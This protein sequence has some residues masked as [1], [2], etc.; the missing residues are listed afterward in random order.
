[1]SATSY[2]ELKFGANGVLNGVNDIQR[3]ANEPEVIRP[4]FESLVETSPIQLG[5]ARIVRSNV[6]SRG[7]RNV[8]HRFTPGLTLVNCTDELNL[9]FMFRP[10]IAMGLTDGRR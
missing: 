8:F 1:V 5:I 10:T 7:S 6:F 2:R 9:Q 4:P 3:A